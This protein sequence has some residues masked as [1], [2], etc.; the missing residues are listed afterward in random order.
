MAVI[1]RS[2][3]SMRLI[4][5]HG[6][7]E[8]GYAVKSCSVKIMTFPSQSPA[9][10]Y[11]CRLLHPPPPQVLLSRIPK[12]VVGCSLKKKLIGMFLL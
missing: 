10:S 12:R 6:K 5:G 3:L 7:E 9:L 1:M 8:L 4:S 11:D 2:K